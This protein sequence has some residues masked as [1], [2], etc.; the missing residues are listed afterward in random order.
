[1][2]LSCPYQFCELEICKLHILDSTGHFKKMHIG[3]PLWK[4][5][6]SYLLQ[7]RIVLFTYN[8]LFKRSLEK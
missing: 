3:L 8:L 5:H 1:M 7:K 4:L 2:G 6:V